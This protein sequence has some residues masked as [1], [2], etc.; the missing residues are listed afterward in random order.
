MT[1]RRLQHTVYKFAPP[2]ATR[3]RR[4]SYTRA[5]C[6]W[7]VL[8]AGR[9]RPQLQSLTAGLFALLGSAHELGTASTATTMLLG[10]SN[11]RI[12][13]L[14]LMLSRS[15]H[16]TLHTQQSTRPSTHWY[17]QP[18]I[19]HAPKDGNCESTSRLGKTQR[20]QQRITCKRRLAGKLVGSEARIFGVAA[21]LDIG[22]ISVRGS[23]KAH[24][25]IYRRHQRSAR[26]KPALY[27]WYR[28]IGRANSGWRW[29]TVLADSDGLAIAPQ[30]TIHLPDHGTS[31]N[32]CSMRSLKSWQCVLCS[33]VP[34]RSCA[35]ILR[36][37]SSS[38]LQYMRPAFCICPSNV[39]RHG[40]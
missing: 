22:R 14:D 36:L 6:A 5:E 7:H 37:R 4:A 35:T 8:A 28:N 1:V 18:F 29:R 20:E 33:A 30:D 11:A 9:R 23:I 2:H 3:R 31:P 27:V 17:L 10:E 21:M 25:S 13:Q 24:S 19:E 26:T 32:A 12:L 40:V 34:L 39:T 15:C 38:S 16:W